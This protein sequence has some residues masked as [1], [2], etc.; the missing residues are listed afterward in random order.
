[1]VTP[2]VKQDAE[3]L[4]EKYEKTIAQLKAEISLFASSATKTSYQPTQKGEI[5]TQMLAFL[6]GHIKDI[7]VSICLLEPTH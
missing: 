3:Q 1:V 7:K 2:D 5:N 4:T 6:R